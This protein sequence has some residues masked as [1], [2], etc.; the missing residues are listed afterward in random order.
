[1]TLHALLQLLQ[2]RMR[3][4]GRH[5]THS[6]F[7]YDFVEQVAQSSATKAKAGTKYEQLAERV[8][9]HYNCYLLEFKAHEV[10]EWAALLQENK[11]ALRGSTIIAV[12][13][14]HTTARHTREW[15]ALCRSKDVNMSIDLYGMGLLIYREEFK[16]KQHF[17]VMY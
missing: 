13:G 17:T 3:A 7:V 15:R 10:A 14:I 12:Q 4:K 6:P 5:G 9:E 8:K 16:Q 11:Q 2:Y 1:M